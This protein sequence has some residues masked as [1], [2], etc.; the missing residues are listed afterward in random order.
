MVLYSNSRM[1]CNNELELTC[2]QKH[3]RRNCK[4]ER[5]GMFTSP[6]SMVGWWEIKA[7][8]SGSSKCRIECICGPL[9]SAPKSILSQT[10]Q[11]RGLANCFSC[12]SIF[13]FLY[14]ENV[15]LYYT[16]IPTHHSQSLR[17][18]LKILIRCMAKPKSFPNKPF[19]MSKKL[20]HCL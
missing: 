5:V 10:H 18:S 7:G 8:P 11:Y 3:L 12:H 14:H 1:L 4:I 15:R 13:S 17:S 19:E 20:Y 16:T 2:N 9:Q 6:S